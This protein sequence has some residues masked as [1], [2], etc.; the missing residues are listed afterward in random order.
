MIIDL[1]GRTAFVSGST[2]GIGRVIAARLAAAGAETTINGRDDDRVRAVVDE[3][4]AQSP[5]ARI[6]G[7]AADVSRPEGAQ[8]VFEAL[9]D[10]D[11]LVNNLG[12]FS[13]QPVL[14]I[15]DDT[16]RRF[17]EVNVM[18]GVRLTRHYLPGMRDRGWGR[19]QFMA[20]DSA[21]VIPEEM[22]HYGVTK[23]A[24]LGVSRGFAKAMAGTG[25]TVNAVIAGP[26]RT[27]GVENFVRSLVGD[28]LPWEQAQDEFMK[29]HRPNSLLR[30]L[31]EPEEIANM[32]VY[33]SSDHASAT[34]GGALRA[35]G[36]YV[37]SILP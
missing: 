9:P 14:E 23:T 33:L 17:W 13:A 8:A 12:I 7:I 30:R 28:E 24:L 4:R 27:R 25:V 36:G 15:D 22:V 18:S 3:L 5:D 20:S 37:D 31:I 16:W 19:V 32:V 2:Q 1:T 21:V 11:V 26:T 29:H 35:D 6:D 10:V 34:T